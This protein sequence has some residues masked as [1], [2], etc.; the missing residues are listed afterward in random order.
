MAN[1]A[2]KAGTLLN[3]RLGSKINDSSYVL[4]STFVKKADEKS[5][6]IS[7]PTDNNGTVEIEKND[8]VFMS[9]IVGENQY[10]FEGYAG[11]YVKKGM[12]T[13]LEV[14]D[15]S[16]FTDLT[17][18]EQRVNIRIRVS[19]RAKCEKTVSSASHE[20]FSGVTMD[21]S[22]GGVS[23]YLNNLVSSN[24]VVEL[25]FPKIKGSKDITVRG[26]ACW[27]KE[28]EKGHSYKYLVGFKFLFDQ[29]EKKE[30]VLAY[31]QA[32]SEIMED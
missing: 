1:F 13:L 12:K 16:D 17:N 24:E 20:E 6:L 9:C 23:M 30:D 3:M 18:F 4:K 15:I 29:C 27:M 5:F 21:I 19:I 8:K 26:K 31:V 14:R 28:N 11:G 7:P 32:V 25:Y 22:S 2:I 10:E